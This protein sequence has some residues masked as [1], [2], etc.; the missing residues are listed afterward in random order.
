MS[1][2]LTSSLF[3]TAIFVRLKIL[4]ANARFPTKEY[5]DPSLSWLFHIFVQSR[6]KG[7][8]RLWCTAK[9]LFL[10]S[11][12]SSHV[13]SKWFSFDCTF[14]VGD[15]DIQCRNDWR[16]QNFFIVVCAY[17]CAALLRVISAVL[18]MGSLQFKQERNS[19][20][21]TLPDD[22]GMEFSPLVCCRCTFF[23]L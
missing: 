23:C 15:V 16:W 13:L 18:M 10:I 1:P 12:L 22:T 3:T 9:C 7:R 19:D 6:Q 5:L 17:I 14:F 4:P 11:C 21:A 20:Q 2:N 8:R